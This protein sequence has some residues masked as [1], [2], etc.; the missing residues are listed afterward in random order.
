[1]SEIRPLAHKIHQALEDEDLQVAL[2]VL[3]QGIR[4]LRAQA[5]RDLPDYEELRTQA[6]RIKE[7]VIRD[8]DRLLAQLKERIESRGGRVFLAPDGRAACQ[9]AIELARRHKVRTIVKSKSMTSEEIALNEALE[10]AGIKVFETDLGERIV[11]LAGERP[12]HLIGPAVHKTKEEVAELF[13]RWLQLKE[14]PREIEALAGL[15]RRALREAF[16][17]AEM[18]I[19]GVNF[20]IAETGTLVL[21]E[22]EGNIRLT[23]QLPKVHLALMGLEKILP[24]L[25][26]LIIFLKL[27]PR[28]ATGQKLTSYI[29]LISPRQT[30]EQEFHLVI[31]DNGRRRLREDPELVEALYCIRCGAC[32]DS[33]PSYQAVGGHVYSGRT[34]MGG[35]GCVWTAA[36]EGLKEAASIN[37]LC[38]GCGRCTEVC[39]VK[40]DLPWL[41][42]VIRRRLRELGHGLIRTQALFGRVELWT[43]WGSRTAPL[44]NWLLKRKTVRLL[45][46]RLF[47]IESRRIL[48]PF[49]RK[50]FTSAFRKWKRGSEPQPHHKVAFFTDCFTDHFEPQIPLAAVHL[51]QRLG[52]EV[53][54]AENV[55]CGRAALSQ[56]L[57]EEAHAKAES[58]IQRL[59]PLLEEGYVI[60]GLEPSCIAALKR[61]YR[62]LVPEEE[63]LKL[64]TRT[65]EVLEYLACLK[66][67]GAL[68][69]SPQQEAKIVYHGHCQQKALGTDGIIV[70][71]LKS[72]PGLEVEVVEVSCCGMAGSFGYKRDFYELSCHLGRR[73]AYQ[74]EGR[75]GELVASGTSCRAQIRQLISREVQHPI[76]ILER[77]T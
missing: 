7:G 3:T 26:D 2:G 37:E 49:Q 57:I 33:C 22:N 77:V 32:L 13:A 31:L 25:E 59:L 23:A 45:A 42:T 29:S 39:P 10:A 63:A 68:E 70:E 38:T 9:Y 34:Y 48:P 50:T 47:S 24:S 54:P 67:Q 18:G 76:Q 66:Q 61:E 16:F 46:E 8:L 65:F 52:I 56:G 74:L 51:L 17:Q 21:L 55:C 20:A 6:R 58:N 11:Q 41:N 15:A 35:I 14:P 53:R 44:S 71:L 36:V 30:S 1:M 69:L 73:L 60:V 12:S 4:F 64:S 19:T 62:R 28:S 40:I 75:E 5:L 27:L 72:L 43:H